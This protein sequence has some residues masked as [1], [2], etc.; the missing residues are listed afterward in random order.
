MRAFVIT[1]INNEKSVEAAERCISSGIKNGVNIEKF[2]AYTPDDKPLVPFILAPI[3]RT[4]V[5]SLPRPPANL[6]SKAL[7]WI[8]E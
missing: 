6:E 2:E 5:Q 7:S 4:D 8:P 3:A 1:I